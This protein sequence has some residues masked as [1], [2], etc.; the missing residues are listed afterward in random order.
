MSGGINVST[1]GQG[2]IA[3]TLPFVCSGTPEAFGTRIAR[4]I[5]LWKK[6]VAQAGVK[7]Q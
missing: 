4:E 5:E 1:R 7:L 2:S 6:I 3:A